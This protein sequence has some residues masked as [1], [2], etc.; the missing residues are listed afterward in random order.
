MSSTL[1]GKQAVVVGAGMAGLAAARALVDYFEHV[2]VLARFMHE[3][4]IATKRGCY[5]SRVDCSDAGWASGIDP[6]AAGL[7]VCIGLAL[8][9]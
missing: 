5:C 9:V 3:R 2:V 8:E 4:S 1:I 6:A 7:G